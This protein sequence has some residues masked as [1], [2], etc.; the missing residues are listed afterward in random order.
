MTR[1]E[2][3][4]IEQ[5]VR[6]VIKELSNS[7]PS[8]LDHPCIQIGNIAT[9]TAQLQEISRDTQKITEHIWGSN[10]NEGTATTIAKLVND[11]GAIKWLARSTLGAVIA[12]GLQ[13]IFHVIH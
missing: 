7:D 10:S 11:M 9:I 1:D 3:D 5:I 6:V 12:L 2:K 4:N 13:M 8:D